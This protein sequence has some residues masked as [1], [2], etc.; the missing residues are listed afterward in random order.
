MLTLLVTSNKSTI[1]KGQA[2]RFPDSETTNITETKTENKTE[3]KT[4]PETSPARSPKI[5]PS[6][7]SKTDLDYCIDPPYYPEQHI[8]NVVYSQQGIIKSFFDI[9][10]IH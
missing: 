10:A 7:G 6:C 1:F 8:L 3:N 4:A 2:V 5:N 9:F